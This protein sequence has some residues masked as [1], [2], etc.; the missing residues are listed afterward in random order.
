[1]AI[2][3]KDQ[4]FYI[5]STAVLFGLVLL[6]Y[7]LSTLTDILVP[8]AFAAFIAVLLNPLANRLQRYK[9]SRGISI[10]IALLIAF[11]AVGAVFYF[12]SSQ[13]V[14]FGDSLPML[15]QKFGEITVSLKQ[16]IQATFGTPI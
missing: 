14:Q 10:G 2:K 7:V 15:K 16:W 1:M 4:P 5:Q 13:I 8:L 3:I 12:L 6:V 9:I 11:L